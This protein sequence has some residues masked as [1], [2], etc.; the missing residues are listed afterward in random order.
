MIWVAGRS[1]TLVSQ[2]LKAT[3]LTYLAIEIPT[4]VRTKSVVER[5]HSGERPGVRVRPDDE[6]STPQ[7]SGSH[8]PLDPRELV[9]NPNPVES[10]ATGTP[11]PARFQSRDQVN[12]GPR[13]EGL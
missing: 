13:P 11:E 9:V 1:P 6:H 2:N 4:H 7:A 5:L 8:I 3:T 10:G 12:P